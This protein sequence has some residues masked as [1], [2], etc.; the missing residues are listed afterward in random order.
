MGTGIGLIVGVVALV[1]AA[2]VVG[3]DRLAL[4]AIGAAVVGG[5][6]MI[7]AG[8]GWLAGEV[9]RAEPARPSIQ[10]LAAD[11][12]APIGE[13]FATLKEGLGGMT[14]PR[15]LIFAGAFL[16]AVAAIAGA[17]TAGGEAP[18]PDPTPTETT[19]TAPGDG[20]LEASPSAS[21]RA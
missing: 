14:A 6:A 7:G 20:A 11:G 2:V 5:L 15:A 13:M 10:T 21:V 19:V 9:L 1:L 8:I 3:E 4:L 16:L 12:F 17:I 18:D